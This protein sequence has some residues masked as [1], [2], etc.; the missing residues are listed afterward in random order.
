MTAKAVTILLVEDDSVDV[1]AFKRGL[2]EVK[3]GNPLL[4]A[5]DGLEALNMLRGTG[6]CEKV[7][8]PYVILLDLNMP[9]MNGYEFL[10]TL[11]R[12]DAL[13]DSVVFVLTTSAAEEDRTR[14]Y[15]MNVAGYIT[16]ETAGLSFV[17]AVEML[18]HY[19]KLVA[20]PDGD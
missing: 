10:E 19:W 14:A 20:L 4:V 11:R 9:R 12:D 2:Q 6:G 16:K 7:P 15:S 3:I 17:K 13:Q 5:R 18:D 1:R 8:R